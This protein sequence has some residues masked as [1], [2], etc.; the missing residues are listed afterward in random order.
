M[1]NKCGGIF[2]TGKCVLTKAEGKEFGLRIR[3]KRIIC[4]D[5]NRDNPYGECNMTLKKTGL[6]PKVK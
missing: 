2:N 6:R 1:S 3:S 4:V 5:G